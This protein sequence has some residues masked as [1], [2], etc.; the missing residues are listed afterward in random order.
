MLLR[1]EFLRKDPFS[2]KVKEN[3]ANKMKYNPLKK[4]YVSFFLQSSIKLT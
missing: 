1:L 4:F 2:Q 3:M